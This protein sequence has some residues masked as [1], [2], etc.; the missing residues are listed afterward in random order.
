[1]KRFSKEKTY[2]IVATVVFHIL[3]VVLLYFL[4]MEQIPPQPEK[5][6]IEMQSAIEDVAGEEFIEAKVMEDMT[7]Q[8]ESTPPPSTPS[9]VIKEPLVAQESE[10][11]LPVDTVKPGKTETV[12]LQARNEAEK[13]LN[14]LE[15]A[16]RK[17]QEEAERKA[18][19]DAER[20]ARIAKSVAGSFGK[21]GQTSSA[22]GETGGV[23]FSGFTQGGTDKGNTKDTGN[24][25]GIEASVGNRKVVG[26][27]NWNIPVQEEGVVVVSVTVDPDGKVIKANAKTT[28]MKLKQIA[29]KEARKVKFNK[30]S[31]V[32]NEEGTVTFRFNLNY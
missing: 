1:M 12:E 29:E 19:E 8:V 22:G 26:E 31:S 27:L 6:N 10:P 7:Q 13:K 15:E 11:S 17:A 9:K 18:K 25:H 14:E 16:R 3:L 21:S 24:G 2:G 5:S 23:G 28:N 4:V 20:K 30:V 32:D